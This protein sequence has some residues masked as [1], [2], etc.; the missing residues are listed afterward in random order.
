MLDRVDQVDGGRR[1]QIGQ[2]NG[3]VSNPRRSLLVLVSLVLN[4]RTGDRTGNPVPNR[5]ADDRARARA[6]ELAVML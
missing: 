4:D 3:T 5:V 6:G 1:H 2:P